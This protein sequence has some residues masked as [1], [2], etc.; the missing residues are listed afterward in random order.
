LNYDDAVIFETGTGIKSTGTIAITDRDR[1]ALYLLG[2][3]ISNPRL[4]VAVRMTQCR[5]RHEN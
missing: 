2:E 3:L 5:L 1:G 4:K